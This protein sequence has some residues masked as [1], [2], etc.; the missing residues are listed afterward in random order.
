MKI[1]ALGL[2][3]FLLLIYST[4]LFSS[5]SDCYT[6]AKYPKKLQVNA[7]YYNLGSVDEIYSSSLYSGSN[8]CYGLKYTSGKKP[9]RQ[10]LSMKFSMIDRRPG[11]LTLTND[12]VAQNARERVIN[13]FLFEVFD[14]YQFPIELKGADFLQFWVTGTWLTTVNIT[15]NSNGVPELVQSGLAPGAFL[16]TNFPRHNFHCQLF[17]P[18]ISWTVRNNYSQS[19]TQNYEVLSKFYFVKMN[20]QLQF[21]NTLVAVYSEIGYD[22]NISKKLNLE[23]EYNF[24]YMYNSSPRKLESVS[25]IYSL[26]LTYK[27]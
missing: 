15:S 22:F 10:I 8:I 6:E 16:E 19:M 4:H 14:T 25:G 11:S 7:G 5:N 20:D 2:G 24:R 3:V 23:C 1:F 13:S 26:G 21:P 27:F 9:V 17:V 12:I 18:I